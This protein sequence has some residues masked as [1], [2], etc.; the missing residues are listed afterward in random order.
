M[1]EIM[2]L[3]TLHQFHGEANYYTYDHLSQ[4]IKAFS[5]NVL[6]VELTPADLKARRPQRFKQEYQYSVYPLLDELKCEVIPLEPSEPEYSELVQLSKKAWEDLEK[7][8]PAAVEQFNLYVRTLY[9]VLFN[10][11]SSPLDVDSPETDRHF[12]VKHRYQNALFGKNEERDWERWN[13]HFLE[14]ILAAVA[15]FPGCR[16]LVL[17]GAEHAY[18]LRKRLRKQDGVR[19]LEASAILSGIT[20]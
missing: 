17:I 6:A 20:G 9:D 1:T 8:N 13:Q 16:M 12:E 15:R 2:V 10:W 4:I 11:W 3:S 5:P 7:H 14:Q 19:L 18:W